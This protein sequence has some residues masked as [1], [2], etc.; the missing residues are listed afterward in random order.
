LIGASANADDRAM[1]TT[2][3]PANP[4][5]V[6]NGLWNECA[7]A[8]QFNSGAV[9]RA[10]CGPQDRGGP[11]PQH[12]VGGWWR[13]LS[14]QSSLTRLT[15]PADFQAVFAA[16]RSLLEIVI[17]TVLIQ[18]EQDGPARM[19]DW[20]ESAKLKQAEA[21]QRYFQGEQNIPREHRHAIG[22][23]NREG[24]RINAARVARGWTRNN[25]TGRHADRWTDR[26]LADDA[27]RADNYETGL[28]LE[29]TYETSFRKMC[30]FVHGSG[31]IGILNLGTGIFP[32]LGGLMFRTCSDLALA[33]SRLLLRYSGLWDAAFE[34]ATWPE[35]FERLRV[36]QVLTTHA[37][38]F[39]TD[40][41]LPDE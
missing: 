9:R 25:G 14:W 21:I 15:S 35:H 37:A 6:S 4:F 34:G 33:H 13:S 11:L 22:F 7:L 36:Q 23:A 27:E 41:D 32:A 1:A 12:H 39:G 3:P 26:S 2:R 38:A 5:D 17:D 40:A 31:A 16:C 20:E 28:D 19:R 18:H 24:A 29:E 8:F 10:L 30:W